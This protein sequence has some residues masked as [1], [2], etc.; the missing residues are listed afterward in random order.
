MSL[1]EP[2]LFLIFSGHFPASW[3]A[4]DFH[5]FC[6][7]FFYFVTKFTTPLYVACDNL[8]NIAAGR[9]DNPFS[10]LKIIASQ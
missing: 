3:Q 7:A 2:A 8:R 10:G 6:T 9:S 1:S 4:S 5:L